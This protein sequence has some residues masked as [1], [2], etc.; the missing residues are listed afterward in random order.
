MLLGVLYLVIGMALISITISF[1]HKDVFI[2]IPIWIAML[3]CFIAG[4]NLAQFL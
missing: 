1:T 3:L 4:L 2:L